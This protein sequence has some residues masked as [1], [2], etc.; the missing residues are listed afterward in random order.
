MVS[1]EEIPSA[2][3]VN[4]LEVKEKKTRGRKEITFPNNVE[5]SFWYPIQVGYLM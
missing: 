1:S 4:V 5:L 3:V 2:L